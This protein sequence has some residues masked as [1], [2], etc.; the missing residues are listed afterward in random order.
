MKRLAVALA[1]ALTAALPAAAAEP[2]QEPIRIGFIS[3]F[4]GPEAATSLDI[5]DGWRLAMKMMDNKMAG[6]PVVT[7]Y[8]DDQWKPDIGR[9]LVDK[10]LQ[11]D[12]VQI[13]TGIN[14]SNI[15]L[16]AV[17]PALDGGAFVISANAG[18]S[19]LAGKGCQPHFF[20]ASHQNDTLYEA[21]GIMANNEKLAS[22][23]LVSAN[24]PAGRDMMNGF[25]KN[26][27]GEVLGE[28]YTA[29]DQLDYASVIADI[30]ARH[31]AG[32]VVFLPGS[33]GLNFT[34]QYVAAGLKDITPIYSGAGLGDQ[35]TLPGMGD[36]AIGMHIDTNWSEQLDN[37]ASREFTAA[38]E[39]E[40]GRIPSPFAGIAYDT[41]RIIAAALS[42][43]NGRIE[44][45]AAFRHALE[46]VK[47]ASIRG[48]FAFNTN[49]FA[50]QN[51]YELVVGR[52]AKGR[53]A[54]NLKGTT[55][56]DL[57]DSFAESC[58]MPSEN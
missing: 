40:Y 45:K 58:Q 37:A 38:F 16:A 20:A 25:K 49:H 21:V 50:I 51:M 10:M 55:V 1:C 24:Y 6:R 26:F 12:K 18:P 4:T 36:A 2:A 47:V 15:M 33:L 41:A 56:T 35:V 11:S 8:G 31:P 48:N 27:H 3:S 5:G 46:T 57:K 29:I 54:G 19:Q 32:V 9:Q 22:A 13:I 28:T 42:T 34:K 23:Y 17:K 52:D 39:K 53:L 14:G 30:R 44:D 43:I 7:V